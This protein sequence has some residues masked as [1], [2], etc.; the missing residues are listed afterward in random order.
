[1]N[2]LA[3]LFINAQEAA[4]AHGRFERAGDFHH[5][6]VIEDVGIHP[7]AGTLQRQLLDIVVNVARPAVD[8]FTNAEHQFR[9]YRS[10]TIFAQ[11]GQ[12]VAQ[13]RLLNQPRRPVRSQ[14]ETKGDKR[15]LAVGGVQGIHLVLQR[16]KGVVALFVRT[17]TCILF[18]LRNLP[19]FSDRQMPGIA[20][21]N[22]RGQHFIN[23]VNGGAAVNVACDLGDDLRRH[24]S[25]GGDRFRRLDLSVAHFKAI[26]QHAF[27]IDQHAVKHREEG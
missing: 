11:S 26:G 23:A 8:A 3:I 12:P 27:Q 21:L 6:I 15:R 7:L 1:M 19:L 9:E 5:L 25:G 24:S 2:L 16:L 22:K 17:L 18:S 20:L 10:F 14:A 4:A 13:N